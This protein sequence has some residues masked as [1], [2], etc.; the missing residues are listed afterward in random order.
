MKGSNNKRVLSFLK[1]HWWPLA[2][3]LVGLILFLMYLP[4]LDNRRLSSVILG[5]FAILLSLAIS[6][7]PSFFKWLCSHKYN[8]SY[9][10]F[11]L[12]VIKNLSCFLG[13]LMLLVQLIM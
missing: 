8:K 4:R 3:A 11:I 1:S 13:V 2:C 7:W 6:I 10:S 9:T 5:I 12:S